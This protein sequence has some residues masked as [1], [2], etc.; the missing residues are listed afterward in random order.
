[1]L[2]ATSDNV[3]ICCDPAEEEEGSIVLPDASRRPPAIG[4]VIAVGPGRAEKSGRTNRYTDDVKPGDRVYFHE[5]SIAGKEAKIGGK[6][7]IA[8]EAPN[9]LGVL[10]EE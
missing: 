10:T 9:I 7:Y 1:M 2:Q 3:I 6:T 4:T 5:C 8:I